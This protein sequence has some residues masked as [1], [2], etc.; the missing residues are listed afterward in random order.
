VGFIG[1]GFLCFSLSAVPSI[2]MT[3]GIFSDASSDSVI[4]CYYPVAF[5]ALLLVCGFKNIFAFGFSY[6]VVPWIMRSGYQGAF[7][8]MVAIQCGVILFALPLWYYGKKLRHASAN[9]KVIS[10]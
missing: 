9:W 2:T 4:D 8:E 10:W 3:Y 6:G 5:D 7:G 1:Y